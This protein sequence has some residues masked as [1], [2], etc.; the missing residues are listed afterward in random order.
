MGPLWF[1]AMLLIFDF[2]YAGWRILTKNRTFQSASG[3]EP[4]CYLKIGAFILVLA[5]AS[6]LIRIPWPLGK[7]VATF[8][9][10]AYLPQYSV[11]SAS[12]S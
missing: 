7:Y 8:P 10:L 3:F 1:A 12:A 6:Y 5:L 2:G 9:S 4:P 11:F